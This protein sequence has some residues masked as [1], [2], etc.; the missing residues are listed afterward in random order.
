MSGKLFKPEQP[1]IVVHSGNHY[2]QTIARLN[3]CQ[4]V[5][6]SHG[7]LLDIHIDP[8]I[9]VQVCME[10]E[11]VEET[12]V[13]LI[14]QAIEHTPWSRLDIAFSLCNVIGSEFE[15]EMNIWGN[16]CRLRQYEN[17]TYRVMQQNPITNSTDNGIPRT[18]RQQTG[19]YQ[20]QHLATTRFKV[21]RNSE[22]SFSWQVTDPAHE[23]TLLLSNDQALRKRVEAHLERHHIITSHADS[24]T[25]AC[26]TIVNN[27][28][29][30]K[31]TTVLV[32]ARLGDKTLSKYASL[33][34]DVAS[35]G[36]R[37]ILLTHNAINHSLIR[38]YHA[39]GYFAIVNLE[40]KTELANAMYASAIFNATDSAGKKCS[41]S[42]AHTN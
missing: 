34:R 15:V 16:G 38:K 10:A 4:S 30:M 22:R 20:L 12:L 32:D 40:S 14:S 29:E 6:A 31:Y 37:F 24:L 39:A 9:S 27:V 13:P 8:R 25:K 18:V 19:K 21:Q 41:T 11:L 36:T 1:E 17:I 28:D 23:A 33:L 5:A 26:R 2:Y 35:P 7:I 3:S 42:G